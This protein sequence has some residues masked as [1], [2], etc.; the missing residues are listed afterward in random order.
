M[1]EMIALPA[2]AQLGVL[3]RQKYPKEGASQFMR[4]YYAPAMDAIRK[5]YRSS[6]PIAEIEAAITAAQSLGSKSRRVNLDRA[7]H[8]FAETDQVDRKLQ[9]H[10]K[11]KAEAALGSVELRASPDIEAFDGKREVVIYYNFKILPYDS[12]AAKRVMEIACWLYAESGLAMSPAQ[13]ELIDL[14]SGILYR[15][16]SVRQATI[17]QMQKTATVIESIWDSI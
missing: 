10:K 8:A 16:K 4:P 17:K 1:A 14:A 5:S 15:G 6:N 11:S 2:H 3:E 9:V 7:L 13:F 12:E